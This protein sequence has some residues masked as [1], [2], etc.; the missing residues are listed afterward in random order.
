M[1]NKYFVSNLLVLF[2]ASIPEIFFFFIR[3]MVWQVVLLKMM[4]ANEDKLKD[5]E[6]ST[7][8]GFQGREKEAIIISMVRSNSKKEV[9]LHLSF[10]VRA[11][12]FLL[13][14]MKASRLTFLFILARNYSSEMSNIAGW[15]F[16]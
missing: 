2:Y 4:K 16:E 12:F 9:F 10:I 15:I 11:N 8:D 3:W 14:L 7:V 1:N 6:I 13:R 5:L